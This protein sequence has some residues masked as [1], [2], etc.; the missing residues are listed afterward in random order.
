M[1][2]IWELGNGDVDVGNAVMVAALFWRDSLQGRGQWK[3]RKDLVGGFQSV[4]DP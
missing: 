4:R 1:A 2:L 3:A